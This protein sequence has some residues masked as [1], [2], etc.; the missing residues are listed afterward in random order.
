MCVPEA[1]DYLLITGT[2]SRQTPPAA[3][4]AP[5]AH[6]PSPG[7]PPDDGIV[8]DPTSTGAEGAYDIAVR[9]R[10]IDGRVKALF[11]KTATV[12][13]VVNFVINSS[14]ETLDGSLDPDP[15]PDADPGRIVLYTSA[16]KR[17]LGDGDLL[18]A[19]TGI[20]SRTLLHADTE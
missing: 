4:T 7:L 2:S 1:V 9:A 6:A 14:T 3:P 11:K 10:W 19:E 17:R 20:E 13:N 16:P 15:D 18:L 12:A 8:R 5:K